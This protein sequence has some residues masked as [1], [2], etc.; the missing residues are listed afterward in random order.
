MLRPAA[1]L[2]ARAVAPASQPARQ[3][4]ARKDTQDS[5]QAANAT[6]PGCHKVSHA[7]PPTA[8]CLPARSSLASRL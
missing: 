8:H 1:W 7:A 3:M 5:S 6:K 4:S 2:R